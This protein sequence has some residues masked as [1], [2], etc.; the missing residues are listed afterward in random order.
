MTA[1]APSSPWRDHGRALALGLAGLAIR[2]DALRA[3]PVHDDHAQ[4]AMLRGAFPIRRAAWDLFSFVRPGEAPALRVDGLLPWWSDDRFA[5][6]MFRPLSSLALAAQLTLGGYRLAHA[7]SA[8]LFVALV[9]AAGD[10]FR[11]TLPRPTAWIATLLL[12]LS[13]A[14]TLPL[15]WVANQ[16][17]LLAVL[18]G[19]VALAALLR[20]RVVLAHVALALAAF[21]GEYALPMLGYSVALSLARRAPARRAA[22]LALSSLGPLLL[23]RALGYGAA[24]SMYLDPLGAPLRWLAEAP[25]RALLLTG[26]ALLGQ[27]TG[28]DHHGAVFPASPAVTILGTAVILAAFALTVRRIAPAPRAAAI[29]W[30]AG[31]GLALVPVLAAPPLP[32]LLLP[33]APGVAALLAVLCAAPLA[34]LPRWRTPTPA[35]AAAAAL[36]VALLVVHAGMVPW[37]AHRGVRALAAT[38]ARTRDAIAAAAPEVA[39]TPRCD[40]LFGALDLEALHYPPMIWRELGARPSGCWRVLTSSVHPVVVTRLGARSLLLRSDGGALVEP[41]ALTA[42]RSSP[43][44]VGDGLVAPGMTITVTEVLAGYPTAL[45][46]DLTGEIDAYAWWMLREGRLGRVPLSRMPGELRLPLPY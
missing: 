2:L 39:P 41:L 42:Y 40:V 7:A 36:A 35:V 24:S 25:G 22:T 9:V 34:H 43:M 23:A 26:A 16:N 28:P 6:A 12:A 5:I 19:L 3:P 1:P 18:L 32:R 17:A 20:G 38:F 11:A 45:R 44:A 4:L 46:L 10:A 27:S 30:A 33:A 13:P 15:L 21:A 29:A 14:A 31:A 37:E 8:L